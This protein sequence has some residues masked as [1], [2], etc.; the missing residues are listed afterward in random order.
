[1]GLPV[2]PP[3]GSRSASLLDL[4]TSHV[5]RRNP[6]GRAAVVHRLDRDTSGI[7][8]FARDGRA[9]KALMDN[10]DAL[11][12]E[13]G[14]VALAEGVP[15][16][17]EGVFED[18]LL[19][20]QAGQ[21]Y[22]ASPQARGSLRALTRWK[23]LSSSSSGGKG[24]G[25]AQPFCLFSLSLET[26]RKHQIRVQLSSRGYP[27]AGDARYGARSDPLGRL[28]LHAAILG[29]EHPFTG[30]R[31]SFESPAPDEFYALASPRRRPNP[32]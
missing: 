11:V 18:F 12:F 25:G 17:D 7:M 27:V 23:L 10:W 15:D 6:K 4:V 32:R 28:C 14:Y 26:G 16:G 20:N 30:E 3:E 21:V 22:V 29:L 2:I 31:F 9:K 8:V 5:Q 13:R 24:S 1:M 19:E